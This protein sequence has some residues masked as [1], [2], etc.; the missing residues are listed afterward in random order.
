MAITVRAMHQILVDHTKT[1]KCQKHRGD[2]IM[3]TL[4]E[5]NEA[6]NQQQP[7]VLNIKDALIN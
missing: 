3:V 1:K 7:D 5:A 2:E 6:Y 4:H